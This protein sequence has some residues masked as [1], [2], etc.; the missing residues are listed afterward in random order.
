MKAW[1]VWRCINGSGKGTM[2]KHVGSAWWFVA[3]MA[4]SAAAQTV[5]SRGS[6]N[7]IKGSSTVGKSP[8]AVSGSYI[9]VGTRALTEA[10]DGLAS[11]RVPLPASEPH[12]CSSYS[13]FGDSISVCCHPS[14]PKN[15]YTNRLGAAIGITTTIRARSGDQAC[16]VPKDQVFPN[17]N[18]GDEGTRLYTVMIG[19]N[20][21]AIKGSGAY[22]S[23]AT[24]CRQA[25]ATWLLTSSSNKYTG[26]SFV[27]IPKNWRVDAA[28]SPNLVGIEST[29]KGASASW[30]I[31]TSGGPIFIWY[32]VIDRNG[33]A[34]SYSLD[35]GAP[36]PVQNST[37]PAMATQ[38]GTTDSVGVVIITGVSDNV[39]S[40]QS[41][42]VKIV[43]T[44]ATGTGSIVSI[45]AVG[46]TMP[47]NSLTHPSLWEAGV[48]R[49]LNDTLS[50]A[51]AAYNTDNQLDATYLAGLGLD[52]SFV[53]VRSELS[54]TSLD[55]ADTYH[56]NDLGNQHLFNAFYR[57]IQPV[58][59][60]NT[61]SPTDR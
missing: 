51:T 16:D 47:F 46:T 37:T 49:Q 33:G 54:N 38:N 45:L 13:A 7:T 19:T 40:A 50:T 24:L 29:T 28:Y 26:G 59:K 31:I 44:S 27:T 57:G 42:T 25:A 3:V 35:G 21:A 43:V 20:D 22:E 34:F 41:H 60:T 56:P 61:G 55:M 15:L 1:Q 4:V 32:R 10:A 23:V 14:N 58:C 30:P 11:N 18:P 6:T 12:V 8:A 36:V 17:E 48:P 5:T 53:D 39:T 9:G 2:I 52:I